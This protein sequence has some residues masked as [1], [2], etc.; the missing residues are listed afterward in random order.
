[1]WQHDQSCSEYG[2]GLVEST[3]DVAARVTRLVRNLERQHENKNI[4]LV[5][6]GDVLQILQTEF[7]GI[8]AAEHRALPMLQTAEIRRLY[9]DVRTA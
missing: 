2:L 6:H 8:P 5:S 1:M 3:A 7:E 4:V 9:S